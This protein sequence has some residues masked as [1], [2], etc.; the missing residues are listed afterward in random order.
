VGS[1]GH[2]EP[3]AKGVSTRAL[4]LV[5]AISGLGGQTTPPATSRAGVGSITG[6]VLYRGR[7]PPPLI[8]FEGG[9]KQHVLEVEPHGKG[10]R[11]AVVYVDARP[12]PAPENL[13]VVSVDQVGWMFRPPVIA[14]SESQ[15]VRF[16]N[17]DGANH[18]IRSRD[19]MPAN[20]IDKFM[21]GAP[22]VGRFV[23]K[24]DVG[25]PVVITCDLHAWMI[26]WVYVFDHRYHAVTD[27]EGRFE[28]TS[29]LAG[30]H[31]LHV[32][33]PGGG[34]ARELD[35]KIVVGRPAPVEVTFDSSD[36]RLPEG[37]VRSEPG[38]REPGSVAPAGH[39]RVGRRD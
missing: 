18:S 13:P 2:E 10:L 24:P 35:L 3:D 7:V 14:V 21:L 12:E 38:R 11:F 20:Q 15:P 8:V 22:Y 25:H 29:V 6:R 28:I 23:R 4:V 9:G 19:E 30:P 26:A 27:G 31:R 33:H 39:G 37:A 16:T 32:R 34:L 36:L 17:S 1:V 5:L